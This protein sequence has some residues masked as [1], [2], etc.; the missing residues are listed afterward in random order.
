V[1]LVTAFR[2]GMFSVADEDHRSRCLVVA[3]KFIPLDAVVYVDNVHLEGHPSLENKRLEQLVSSFASIEKMRKKLEPSKPLEATTVL[4]VGDFNTGPD[5]SIFK[6]MRDG[7]LP[8]DE[9]NVG[10]PEVVVTSKD[11]TNSWT[12]NACADQAEAIV[13]NSECKSDNDNSNLQ[14][15]NYEF[16]PT[17][18][19]QYGPPYRVDFIWYSSSSPLRH[20]AEKEVLSSSELQFVLKE[21][22]PN[23]RYPSDHVP[24][25]SLFEFRIE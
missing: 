16:T 24:I 19:M 1:V 17:V 18:I 12:F 6:F 4:A 21:S 11:I 13:R 9:R 5:R 20:I 3:L 7:K 2:K 8:A 14:W 15:R 25:A 22:N 23:D 10:F